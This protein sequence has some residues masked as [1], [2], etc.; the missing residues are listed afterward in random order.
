M[1]PGGDTIFEYFVDPKAGSWATW[2]SKLSGTFKPPAGVPAFRVGRWATAPRCT[3]AAAGRRQNAVW[4][5]AFSACIG[6]SS[7]LGCGSWLAASGP[8][9]TEP[10]HSLADQRVHTVAGPGADGGHCAH[11]GAGGPAAARLPPHA[12]G[13]WHSY[14]TVVLLAW[15]RAASIWHGQFCWLRQ[16]RCWLH[17]S[18]LVACLPA[19]VGNMGVGKTMVLNSLLEALPT[20]RSHMTINFSAQASSNS[21][22]VRG[23]G[24]SFGSRGWSAIWFR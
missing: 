11:E 5:N 17:P 15:S 6:A 16:T 9:C 20:E 2:E 22:Q 13:A 3:A 1:L 24:S 14:C 19:Q 21:L 18:A 12:G 8:A 7:A 23:P 10:M 4:H